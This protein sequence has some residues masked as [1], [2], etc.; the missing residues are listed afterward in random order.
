MTRLL[1]IYHGAAD[2]MEKEQL[3]EADQAE[4]MSAWASWAQ[5]HGHSLVDPGAPLSLKKRVTAQGVEDVTDSKTGCA[6]VEATSHDEAVRMFAEHPH[7]LLHSGNSIEV[8]ECPKV[9]GQT[10]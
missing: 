7:L 9:P 10:G 2:Q 3:S 6:I 8:L 4:F 1:A 5:S